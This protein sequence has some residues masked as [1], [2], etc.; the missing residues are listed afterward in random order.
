ML[1]EATKINVPPALAVTL[2]RVAESLPRYENQEFYDIDLQSLVHERIRQA[3]R[4]DFEWL[5]A[6]IRLRVARRPYCA[7]VQGLCFDE[8]NRLFVALNRAFGELVARPYERPR[9]QLVHYIQAATDLP[10]RQG[11]QF[12]SEKLHTD[13]ADWNPP[14]Q[15]ISMVCV[16]ADFGGGGRSRVLDI[17]TLRN[18][19]RSR[20]GRAALEFLGSEPVPWLMARY[21]GGGVSWRPVLTELSICWRKYTIESAVGVLGIELP[22]AVTA[23]LESLEQ[24]VAHAPGTLE[25]LMREGDLLFVDNHKA[26]HSRTPLTN[27]LISNRL[28]IR[29]WV[30]PC[31]TMAGVG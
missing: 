14:V 1:P 7:L 4:S 9:A 19:V 3:V 26:L 21:R 31:G 10:A 15:L 30:A 27:P 23:A 2:L 20:L 5:V 22:S 13:A 11:S 8:G 24:V 25:F 12:E 16:R 17:D 6:E 18:E 29:S 28:M